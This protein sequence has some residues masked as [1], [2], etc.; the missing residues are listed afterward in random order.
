[1]KYK[2]GQ[3]YFVRDTSELFGKGINYFNQKKFPNNK[4]LP[5]HVGIIT[6]IRGTDLLIHEAGPNGFTS[7]LYSM[8]GVDKQIET[9]YAKIGECN[10]KLQDVFVNAEHYLGIGYGWLDI[11][12]IAI[13]YYTGLDLFN[14]GKNKIICSE[15]VNY[16]IYDST[17][18]VNFAAEYLVSPDEV[19]PAHIFLSKQVRIL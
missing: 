17:K 4:W 16:V 13:H 1:M 10:E 12:D 6:D 7:S 2:I 19:S 5:T 15:A 11:L 18:K 14:T 8:E 9:E 3:L